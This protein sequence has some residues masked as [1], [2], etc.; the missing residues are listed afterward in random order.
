M[1]RNLCASG[2]VLV[3]AATVGAAGAGT[4]WASGPSKDD[5]A[6]MAPEWDGE[7]VAEPAP[8]VAAL[9]IDV[10]AGEIGVASCSSIAPGCFPGQHKMTM[11]TPYGDYGPDSH[12]CNAP[13]THYGPSCSSFA[14]T[15]E[16]AARANLDDLRMMLDTPG[17]NVHL[18]GER[19]ALQVRGC[20]EHIIASFPMDVESIAYLAE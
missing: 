5:P 18:N 14:F 2:M 17:T 4:L 6:A 8:V 13:A 3:F 1:Y 16:E 15:P 10:M 20:D 19:M 11:E 7:E 9:M 12:P